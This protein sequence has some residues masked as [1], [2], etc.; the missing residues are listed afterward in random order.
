[1]IRPAPAEPDARDRAWYRQT[2]V[3]LGAAVFALSVAGCIWLIAVAERWDDPPLPV[4]GPQVLKVPLA[5]P[6]TAPPTAPR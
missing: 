3:W 6:G 5:R 1:M 2:I 4:A